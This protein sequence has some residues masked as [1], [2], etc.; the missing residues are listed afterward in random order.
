M[1][2]LCQGLGVF[3][4]ERMMSDKERSLMEMQERQMYISKRTE[5]A[6]RQ[7]LMFNMLSK[8]F[9]PMLLKIGR[10]HV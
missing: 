4:Q 5:F 1:L 6:E 10:A 3:M 8:I 2:S 7:Q 9:V